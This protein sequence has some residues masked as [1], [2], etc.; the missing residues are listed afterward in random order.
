MIKKIKPQL[1]LLE[2][3]EKSDDIWIAKSLGLQINPHAHHYKLNFSQIEQDWL[4]ES[5]KKFIS[6]MSSTKEFETL[7]AYIKSL[8]LFSLYLSQIEYKNN[9]NQID[10]FIIVGFFDFLKAREI[11][12]GY[13]HK[14]ISSLAVFFETGIINSWFDIPQYLIRKEDYPKKIKTVPRYI[15][16][17]VMKQLNQHLD[18]LPK[19]V[20]RMVLVL[21]ECG[22]RIGELCQLRLNCLKQD[23]KGDFFLDFMR[24]KM[25]KESTIPISLELVQVIQTQQKYIQNY[26]GDNFNYLFSSREVGSTEQGFQPAPRVMRQDS[27][28]G[29]LKRLAKKFDI[30]DASGTA[31]EFQTHQFRHTV[32][33]RMI[34]NGVPQHIIQRYLGHES[35]KMTSVYA[36]IHDQTLKQEIAKYHDSRVVNIAGEV[37]ESTTPELDNDLDL[38]LLKKKVLAQSLPNGSCAR[39]VVLGECPHANACLTCGDFRT[40]IEFLDQHK[41]QLKETDKLIKNA[42]E[43]GWKRHAEM[44]TKVR[45]NLNKIITTLESGNKDIVS[46]GDE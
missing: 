43:Q 41:A 40:T 42:E 7:R 21:Q 44:N 4:K 18:S 39:P 35:P 24:W 16:E 14:T 20:M 13:R 37:V 6:Y 46:G 25:K 15:P 23:A 9:F 1:N 31:W 2:N 34:N 11:S 12:L 3:P 26:F 29:Y 19:P 10:R 36:H 8:R 30:R 17:E 5:A 32:G 27:F 22:L 45:D 38:Y 33:T 28:V